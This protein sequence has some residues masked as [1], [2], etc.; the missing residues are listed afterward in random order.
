MSCRSKWLETS[1]KPLKPCLFALLLAAC[2]TAAEPARQAA[3]IKPHPNSI[4]AQ[5]AGEW[6]HVPDAVSADRFAQDRS[7]CQAFAALVPDGAGSP[8]FRGQVAYLNCLKGKGYV[9]IP[10]QD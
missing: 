7:A 10:P 9:P 8:G 5:L 2:Q 1:T 6:R 3:P 4:A